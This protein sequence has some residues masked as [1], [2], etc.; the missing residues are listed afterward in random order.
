M[1]CLLYQHGLLRDQGFEDIAVIIDVKSHCQSESHRYEYMAMRFMVIL[2]M[3]N[4]YV[5][6]VQEPL[7]TKR[8]KVHCRS[9]QQKHRMPHEHVPSMPCEQSGAYD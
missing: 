4:I 6:T 8:C 1:R 7:M 2:A 5:L 3:R 9:P